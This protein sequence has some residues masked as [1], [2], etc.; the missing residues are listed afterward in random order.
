MDNMDFWMTRNWPEI[1]H[2]PFSRDVIEKAMHDEDSLF[3]FDFHPLHIA[4]NTTSVED[5]VAKK[6]AVVSGGISP[7]DLRATGRGT[8]TF[9][10]DLVSEMFRRNVKSASCLEA[11]HYFGCIPT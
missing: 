2:V 6:H 7:F 9:F 5:Y 1:G 10:E 4:L 3:V 11:L 8:A